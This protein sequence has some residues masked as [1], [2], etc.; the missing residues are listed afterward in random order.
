MK[1]HIWFSLSTLSL[2]IASAVHADNHGHSSHGMPNLTGGLKSDLASAPARQ[3]PYVPKGAKVFFKNLNNGQTISQKYVVKFGVRKMKVHPAG[4]LQD[5]TGH[6]HIVINEGPVP[7]GQVVPAD[8]KHIHFGKGQTEFEL[9]LKP[10]QYK[11]TLQFA[12]G[13]H[14]SYGPEL[15]ETVSITVK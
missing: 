2:L 11:L 6:H 15:S 13:A 12:D 4:E 14:I 7:A 9:V 1:K 3:G 10:G 5:G 8:D